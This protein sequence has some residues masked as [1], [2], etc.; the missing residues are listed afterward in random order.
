MNKVNPSLTSECVFLQHPPALLDLMW[1]DATK[2]I[3]KTQGSFLDFSSASSYFESVV[4]AGLDGALQRGFAQ[5]TYELEESEQEVPS[6][7]YDWFDNLL[8]S[9]QAAVQLRQYATAITEVLSGPDVDLMALYT[10]VSST[11]RKALDQFVNDECFILDDF[12]ELLSSDTDV[13]K[14]FSALFTCRQLCQAGHHAAHDWDLFLGY[15]EHISF[16]SFWDL[17]IQAQKLCEAD[18]TEMSVEWLC[19]RM[20]IDNGFDEAVIVAWLYQ[21][22]E[23]STHDVLTS[24]LA[25]YFPTTSNH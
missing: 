14:R 6:S 12:L 4:E 18:L 7:L 15:L 17:G 1:N 11:T 13:A 9:A 3:Q 23:E 22:D 8:E 25:S 10:D 21:G 19:E 20:E 16:P 5:F 2:E 24:L